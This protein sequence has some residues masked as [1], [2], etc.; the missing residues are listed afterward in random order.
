MHLLANLL[1]N[2]QNA[3]LYQSLIESGLAA[4]YGLAGY[5]DNYHREPPVSF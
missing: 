3:P 2:G 5:D 4:G 1:L